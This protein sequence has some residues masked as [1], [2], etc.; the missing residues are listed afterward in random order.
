M[1]W[2]LDNG[3]TNIEDRRKVLGI[4]LS[5]ALWDGNLTNFNM[6]LAHGADVNAKVFLYSSVMVLGSA[7]M[8]ASFRNEQWFATSWLA[9]ADEAFSHG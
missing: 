4:L 7:N 6:L 5:K 8:S 1:Q 2:L 9:T 3:P